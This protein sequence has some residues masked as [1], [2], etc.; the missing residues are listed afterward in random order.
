VRGGEWQKAMHG[1]VVPARAATAQVIEGGRRPLGWAGLAREKKE[2]WRGSAGLKQ[3]TGPE[4]G[5]NQMGR[6]N[7]FS[8][9][10]NKVLNIQNRIT[11]NQLYG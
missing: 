7:Y 4:S 8:D 3:G 9:F 10:G 1:A 5:F 2:K 11:S 6:Q